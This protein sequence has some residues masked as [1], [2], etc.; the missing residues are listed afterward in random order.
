MSIVRVSDKAEKR[1]RKPTREVKKRE[2]ER[3]KK[4]DEILEKKLEEVLPALKIRE[5]NTPPSNPSPTSSS[6]ASDESWESP[7]PTD[8][9]TQFACCSAPLR[10]NSRLK[11]VPPT[12]QEVSGLNRTAWWHNDAN[13][14]VSFEFTIG[15]SEVRLFAQ[16]PTKTPGAT[17]QSHSGRVR[18][19]VSATIF[20]I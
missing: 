11:F 5:D 9:S 3:I 6:S 17:C 1:R 15:A 8:S 7:W 19:G 2:A 10:S 12:P 13:K 20:I 16:P 14:W 18:D 4:R